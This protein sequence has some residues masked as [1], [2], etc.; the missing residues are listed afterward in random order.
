[1][2]VC[3]LNIMLFIY[4]LSLYIIYETEKGHCTLQYF[5]VTSPVF[6]QHGTTEDYA[7]LEN[8]I[9]W[10]LRDSTR[11][12]VTKPRVA[13]SQNVCRGRRACLGLITRLTL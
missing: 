13:P 12:L 5:C 11:S 10:S 2:H 1:M 8:L 4:L 9:L 6:H 7:M 3:R